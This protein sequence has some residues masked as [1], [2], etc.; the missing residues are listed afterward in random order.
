MYVQE[1][2][3]MLLTLKLWV[4]RIH[5]DKLS[6]SFWIRVFNPKCSIIENYEDVQEFTYWSKSPIYVMDRMDGGRGG[7]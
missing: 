6:S 7:G 4:Y 5:K 2:L 3:K 1:N